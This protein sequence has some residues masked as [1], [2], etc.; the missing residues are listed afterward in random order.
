MHKRY[1]RKYNNERTPWL[2]VDNME[3][4]L[5]IFLCN[6]CY[7]LSEKNSYFDVLKIKIKYYFQK[8]FTADVLT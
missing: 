3:Y 7:V 8:A 1:Y 4:R 6:K 5:T 2:Y